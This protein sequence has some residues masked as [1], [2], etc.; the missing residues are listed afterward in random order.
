MRKLDVPA[1]IFSSRLTNIIKLSPFLTIF[2]LDFT[3]SYTDKHG[4]PAD[5]RELTIFCTMLSI[6]NVKVLK[7]ITFYYYSKSVHPCTISYRS[8]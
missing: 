2:I 3:L 1:Q 4:P 6:R 8:Y 5:K 7:I